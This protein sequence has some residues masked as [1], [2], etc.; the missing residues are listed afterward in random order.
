LAHTRGEVT[1]KIFRVIS[2][3]HIRSRKHPHTSNK[4]IKTE[5]CLGDFALKIMGSLDSAPRVAQT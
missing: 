1:L 5:C 3:I 2:C 4:G